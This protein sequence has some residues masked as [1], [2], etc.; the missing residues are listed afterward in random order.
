MPVWTPMVLVVLSILL[1]CIGFRPLDDAFFS[2]GGDSTL[3]FLPYVAIILLVVGAVVGSGGWTVTVRGWVGLVLV[4]LAILFSTRMGLGFLW[5]PIDA[6][7]GSL[8]IYV[9]RFLYFNIALGLMGIMLGLTSWPTRQG[10]AAVLAG[11]VLAL[12]YGGLIVWLSTAMH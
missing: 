5:D 3:R 2:L 10:K 4:L 9:G 12:M 6:A 1:G 8:G 11:V 7:L